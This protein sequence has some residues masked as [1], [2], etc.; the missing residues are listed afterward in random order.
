MHLEAIRPHKIGVVNDRAVK[1]QDRGHAFNLKLAQ[2][3]ARARQGLFTGGAG[4]D[5]FGHQGVKRTR[6]HRARLHA[7][8]QPHAGA[9]W[10]IKAQHRARRGQKA[11]A[12]VFGVDTKF[13]GMT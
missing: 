7:G 4:D 10:W 13:D 11:P 9:G 12:H 1:R 8:I 6:H 2:R 3:P 5:Q